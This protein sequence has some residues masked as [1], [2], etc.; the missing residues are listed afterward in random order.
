M[1]ISLSAERRGSLAIFPE[2]MSVTA[3][4]HAASFSL[5]LRDDS[6]PT[7]WGADGFVT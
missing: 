4:W 5:S 1:S 6:K 2:S 3:V 7:R